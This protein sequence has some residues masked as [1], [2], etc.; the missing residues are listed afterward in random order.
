MS[1]LKVI[2]LISIVGALTAGFLAFLFFSG[3]VDIEPVT[4]AQSDAAYAFLRDSLTTPRYTYTDFMTDNRPV[5]KAANE[6]TVQGGAALG[7]KESLIFNVDVPA[8]G[9]YYFKL[10]YKALDNSF[11][12]ITVALRVNGEIQYSEANTIILP[13]FWEDESKTYPVDKYGDETSPM[14]RQIPGPHTVYLFDTRYTADLPLNFLLRQGENIVEINN[15]TSQNLWLGDL[16]ACSYREPSPYEGGGGIIPEYISISAVDYVKKNSAHA[17]SGS[18]SSPHITPYDPVNLKINTISTGRSG[19][20]IFYHFFAPQ[21]GYYAITFHYQTDVDD[22]A[23]FISVKIDGEFPFA[24]ASSYALA[25]EANRWRNQTLADGE[26]SPYLFYLT[27]G[28]HVL[29]VKNELS[30]LSRQIRGLR[31]LIDHLNQFAIEIKKITGKTVDRNRTW[32]LT[33]YIPEVKEYLDA[34]DIIFRSII[35]DLSQYSPKGADSSVISPMVQAVSYLE[36]LRKKYDELPLYIESLSGQDASVL[37]QAGA[38]LDA[39]YNRVI[40]INAVYLG[41]A[42]N[43]PRENAGIFAVIAD[44]AKKLWNSYTSD[45]YKVRNQEDALN[46]WYASSYM[47][48]DLLQKLADTRFT[49]RTGIKVNISVMPDAT[50]LIMARA[51]RTNPDVALGMGSW[52]PSELALRG[53]LFDFTHF[54]D[55]WRYM[56]GFVPGA[57]TSYVLNEKVYAVPETITFAATVYREDILNRLN[58][59]P[60]DTWTDVAEMMAELQRFDMSFYMPIASGT[61]YKWF[62]QTSPLIYQNNG[63]LYRPDGLGTAI[64]ETNAVKGLTFLGDLFTTYALAEQVPNYFNSFR[65]GQTPVG[66]IDAETYVLLTYGAPELMGQWSIA[67]FPGTLQEDGSILRWFIAN[68]TGSVIFENTKRPDDCWE[69]LKWFLSDETQTDFAFTLFANYRIFHMPSNINALRNIP[70]DDKDKQVILESVPW[71]RDAP[72]SP[73]QYLLERGLSDIWNTIV[74]DGTPVRVAIDRQVIEIQRE[75]K[76]KMTEF[77]YLNSQGEQV[78]PYV[79]REIDWI[80][81]QIENA[82]QAGR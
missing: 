32:R 75:F 71:L 7:E 27:Q 26:G 79:L 47:Q 43:L 44:G 6:I 20:E 77:G 58:I 21:D 61:G 78:K 17:T 54:E 9:L 40:R 22:F 52:M 34:Y 69:F 65:L 4:R 51:A 50:K 80:I 60:P 23:S 3:E 28:T 2:I 13:V 19:D 46:V 45:K 8:G 70:I 31:L 15:E 39:L 16:T 41:R 63:L 18:F 82:R 38:A 56:G 81:E 36:K 10:E 29:S 11:T 35:H 25:P 55:F 30:P 37:Q 68:G 5:V 1:K 72:R 57:L 42:E 66:I 76:K 59:A 49:P 53:A 14:Q 67:P 33:E 62:Y 48:V 64:N 74:F 73:G 24:E 12:D